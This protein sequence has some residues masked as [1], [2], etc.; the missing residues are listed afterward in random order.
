MD[1]YNL[2]EVAER[3]MNLRQLLDISPE[4]MAQYAGVSVE[5]Y[6]ESETGNKDFS[7]NF[8]YNCSKAL[9]VDITELIRGDGAK[10]SSF[11]I[12]RAGEGLPIERR[13]GF[14]YLHLAANLKGRKA[15]PFVVSVPY[16]KEAEEAAIK[17]STHEGQE[18]DYVLEGELKVEI[19]GHISILKAG[20][21]VYYDSGKPHGMVAAGGKECKFL[22]IVF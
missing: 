17:L 9:N 6:L 20:D 16:D 8:L 5:E 2:K 21:C 10:L 14:N 18:M 1:K 7:F 12:T 4:T 22:A 13:S 19:D 3:L 15:E 11:T